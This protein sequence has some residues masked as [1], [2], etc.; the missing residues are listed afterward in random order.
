MAKMK[1]ADQGLEYIAYRFYGIP[2]DMDKELELKTFG[3]CRY[4]WNRMLG[5]HNELYHTVGNVPD[6]TP[7]DYKD[8]DE[9][10]WL[11]GVDSL[12]LAN[13]QMNL[14]HA[15]DRFYEGI[16][17]YPK[18]KSKKW[19][20]KSYTTNALYQ[21]KKD[22]S[23]GCNIVLDEQAGTLKLPKHK[24]LVMLRMHRKPRAGGRLKSVTVSMEPDGKFYYSILMEYQKQSRIRNIDPEKA[25]A[26]DMSLPKFYID[27]HG[28]SPEFPKPY[29]NMEKRL[30]TEQRKLSRKQR[31]SANYERQRQKVAKLH[32]K[33]KH[34]R[35]DFL[36]KLSC[37]I[38][39]EYDIIGIEDLDMSAVKQALRF[40]KSV[41]DNGWGMFIDMV[42]YKAERKGKILIRVSK[43]FPSSKKC[44][45]CEHIHKELKLSDRIYICPVCG[46]VMDRDE[47]AAQNIREE[48]VR[49]WREQH[50]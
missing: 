11:N 12:A 45:R 37:Q 9:C 2:S 23:T 29:R 19:S 6:N 28:K 30:A 41:S 43:W 25:I 17:R 15:F 5:D 24:D 10:Q 7:A 18:F 27:D 47:Q 44:F 21:K 42:G 20:R 33:T 1:K 3:C 31:G 26:L 40:G 39:E 50:Q 32:A 38:T 35:S 16:S 48:T 8:L 46:N 13:V 14:K 34:Q 4:L 22:G 49:I 36:H